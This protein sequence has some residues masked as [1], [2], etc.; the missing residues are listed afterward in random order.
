M[1]KFIHIEKNA[2]SSF[3]DMIKDGILKGFE[4]YPHS[5]NVEKL[6][7]NQMII[8]RDPFDRFASAFYFSWKYFDGK[9]QRTGSKNPNDLA[10]M[11]YNNDPI[12]MDSIRNKDLNIGTRASGIDYIFAPQHYS[13]CNPKYVLFYETLREDFYEL[14]E[15]I[16]HPRVE[17]W[18]INKGRREK[19][20][21]SDKSIKFIKDF[22]KHDFEAINYF[23]KLRDGG[24]I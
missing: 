9:L 4:Y 17:L 14:L 8:L 23:R 5:C 16:Q 22:Y 7:K 12:A 10:E 18:H 11:L 21:Y 20:E 24:N 19:F 13:I 1:I 15:R 6:G 2:G 3:H